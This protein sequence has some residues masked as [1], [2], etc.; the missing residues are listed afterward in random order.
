MYDTQACQQFCESRRKVSPYFVS[1]MFV[2]VFSFVGLGVLRL[3]A[4]RLEGRLHDINLQIENYEMQEVD[5]RRDLSSLTSP[6]A[7][8]GYSQQ[9]LGMVANNKTEKV[10][11]AMTNPLHGQKKNV[12]FSPSHRGRLDFLFSLFSSQATAKE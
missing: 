3:Y 9:H 1:F 11:V 7:I 4:T 6:E 8:Y 10:L 2:M 12:A 5:M